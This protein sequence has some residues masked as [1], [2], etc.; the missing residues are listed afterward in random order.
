MAAG[1]GS[2]SYG[3]VMPLLAAL[4][5]LV[6]SA[7]AP[8]A[9]APG[10]APADEPAAAEAERSGNESDRLET[11]GSTASPPPSAYRPRFGRG[12]DGD[13][14]D[15]NVGLFSLGLPEIID[16]VGVRHAFATGG[17]FDDLTQ[18]AAF[19]DFR[20]PWHFVTAGGLHISPRLTLEGG[21]FENGGDDRLFASLGPAVR[22]SNPRWRLPLVVDAG[23]SPTFID[24]SEYDGREFGTSV[25][26]T[27]HLALGLEFGE[28]NRYRLDLRFQH[29]SNGGLNDDNPGVNMLGLGFSVGSR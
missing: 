13:P 1:P 11:R 16:R 26:F 18:Q 21:R 25:N 3:R 2:R 9:A 23:V 14:G 27:S 5:A 17:T 15:D 19:I 10:P 12:T 7:A 24:G 6:G 4:L 8:V 22:L 20:L 28:R 29:I